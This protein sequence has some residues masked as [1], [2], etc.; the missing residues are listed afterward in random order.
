MLW[1]KLCNHFNGKDDLCGDIEGCPLITIDL[2][3]EEYVWYDP[4]YVKNYTHAS[5]V[6]H[7][8]LNYMQINCR[9]SRD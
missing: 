7:V 9:V 3:E 1:R 6:M 5:C 2:V 4:I 8:Y